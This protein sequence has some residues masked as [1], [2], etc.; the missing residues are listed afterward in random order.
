MSKT[1]LAIV[2][3]SLIKQ[4]LCH[5]K[6]WFDAAEL[7]KCNDAAYRAYIHSAKMLV[8]HAKI[9]GAWKTT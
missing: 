8:R 4:A 1:S 7:Q 2:V 6:F 5:R 3:R 9:C